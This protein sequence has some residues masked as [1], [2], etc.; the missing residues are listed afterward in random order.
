MPQLRLSF[1]G[2]SKTA[3]TYQS[4]NK[5]C[6]NCKIGF[7]VEPD[8]FSFYEKIQVPP[9]TFC[10]ECRMIRRMVWRNERTLYRRTCSK[11]EKIVISVYPAGVLFPVYCRDCYYSDDHDQCAVGQEYDFSKPFFMQFKKLQSRAPRMAGQWSPDNINSEYTNHIA[12]CKNCYLSF[13]SVNNEDCAYAN[14]V[15]YSK[16]ILDGLRVFKSERCYECIDC[17]NCQTLKYSQLS[18]D[19]FDSA[20]LYNC[21]GCSNCI[22]CT[23]LINKSYCILNEQYSKEDYKKKLE[24]FGIDKFTG[25]ESLVKTFEEMKKKIPHRAVEGVNSI[26]SIGSMLRNTKNCKQCFDVSD[27]EDCKY[28]AYANNAK[29]VMDAY[30]V[31][32]KTELCY[33]SAALGVNSYRCFFSYLPWASNEIWYSDCVQQGSSNLFGCTQ[34]L[35]KSYCILNKQYTKEEYEVLAP[36]II[37]HMNKMP[38]VDAKGRIYK[39]GEFFPIEISPFAYNETIA[40]QYFPITKENATEMKYPWRESVKSEYQVTKRGIELPDS[41]TDVGDDILKEVIQ[42]VHA[43][44][45]NEQCTKAFKITPDEL[46]FYRSN[47]VPLPRL[48]PNCRHYQR[49]KKRNPLKLWHRK[50]QCTGGQSENNLYKNT[51]SHAHESSCPNE[52]ETSYAPDR[53]EIVYCDQCYQKEVM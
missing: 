36:K 53:P 1:E 37:E 28:M 21:R 4:E 11:C 20:F 50:C 51:V 49:L 25:K 26:D 23:N 47:K 19:C 43:D 33:E 52:F 15:S 3:M 5:I 45:C 8:D 42:C 48:C 35:K 14:Y 27:A 44:N 40:Q 2:A 9:P 7:T 46:S 30:A 41:I 13:A 34:M 17:T 10:S 24:E 22:L 16:Y 39:F 12:S 31:Y 38:Y 6:Q 29:D 32:P 18:Q